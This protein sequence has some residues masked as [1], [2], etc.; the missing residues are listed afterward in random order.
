MAYSPRHKPA[1]MGGGDSRGVEGEPTPEYVSLESLLYH[2]RLLQGDPRS[3][4]RQRM[5]ECVRAILEESRGTGRPLG[6]AFHYAGLL[7]ADSPPEL[8]DLLRGELECTA[9]GLARCVSGASDRA[10]LDMLRQADGGASMAR[11]VSSVTGQL[12]KRRQEGMRDFDR[13]IRLLAAHMGKSG[14]PGQAMHDHVVSLARFGSGTDDGAIMAILR[15]MYVHKGSYGGACG[16]CE[17]I[18]GFTEADRQRR[19]GS[20]LVEATVVSILGHIA[21]CGKVGQSGDIVRRCRRMLEGRCAELELDCREISGL[22]EFTDTHALAHD[23]MRRL[24]IRPA[25]E[26]DG[27]ILGR[28]PDAHKFLGLGHGRLEDMVCAKSL[29]ARHVS[30]AMGRGHSEVLEWLEALLRGASKNGISMDVSAKWKREMRA[31]GLYS[32]LLEMRLYAHLSLVWKSVE[33]DPPIETG[34]ADFLVDGCHMEAYAPHSRVWPEARFL[35]DAQS[36][37]GLH[38]SMLAKPQL[39]NFGKR[40]HMLIAECP[41]D[42]FGNECLRAGLR[43]GMR[44]MPC[45]GGVLLVVYRQDR[46]STEFVPNEHAE[47]GVSRVTVL[48][49]RGA[50]EEPL[51]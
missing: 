50:L 13:R 7:G 35:G 39:R 46:F 6:R 32:M 20:V 36:E 16:I 11:A 10:M 37:F 42:S 34:K 31:H 45:L 12:G 14:E 49:A 29:L 8:W 15:H 33:R 27:W 28:Y 48:M 43:C 41:D 9:D 51:A 22:S 18:M 3:A 4:R 5:V 44:S 47:M 25:G 30:A 23:V 24:K 21:E 38:R 2:E 17:E 40:R 19:I 1:A 26:L